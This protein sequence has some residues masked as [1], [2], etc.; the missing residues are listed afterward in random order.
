V[1]TL[2]L[3]T[4]CFLYLV[5]ELWTEPASFTVRGNFIP[6]LDNP[7]LDNITSQ[8]LSCNKS[9]GPV[10]LLVCRFV[11]CAVHCSV[12]QT[13][14]WLVLVYAHQC[15]GFVTFLVRILIWIRKSVPMTNGSGFCYFRH[16]PS[17]CQTKNN[18][19]ILSFSA[20]YFLKVYLH[21][22]SKIKSHK[23][24]RKHAIGIKIFLT[25]FAWW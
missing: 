15:C 1:G 3:S 22:F 23:E 8:F 21:Y 17:R 25:S 13:H 9:S 12:C 24:V 18:F 20:Y 11:W 4:L 14:A 10:V 19:F 16:W 2:T 6:I 5:L 7:L